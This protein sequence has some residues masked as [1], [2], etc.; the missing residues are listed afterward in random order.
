MD[1]KKENVA[2][3]PIMYCDNVPT[4]PFGPGPALCVSQLKFGQGESWCNIPH[5]TVATEYEADSKTYS[6]THEG[7]HSDYGETSSVHELWQKLEQTD[8]TRCE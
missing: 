2:A 5:Y 8:F 6:S 1:R 3:L 7:T 4:K